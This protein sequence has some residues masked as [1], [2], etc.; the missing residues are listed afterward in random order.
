MTVIMMSAFI[1][2]NLLISKKTL[3]R[4][5]T[6]RFTQ[7]TLLLLFL[8]RKHAEAI[9]AALTLRLTRFV[10]LMQQVEI[11]DIMDLKEIAVNHLSIQ[12][13]NHAHLTM[14]N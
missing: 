12:V 14:A 10:M 13:L 6:R 3:P 5:T 7:D 2:S 8:K 4:W 9:I 1:H 11:F